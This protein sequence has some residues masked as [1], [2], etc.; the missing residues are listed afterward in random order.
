[1]LEIRRWSYSCCL[2]SIDQGAGCAELRGCKIRETMFTFKEKI[3]CCSQVQVR[4]EKG[5]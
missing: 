3:Q 2:E 1:M 4:M 5:R